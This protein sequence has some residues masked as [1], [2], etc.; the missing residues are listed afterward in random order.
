MGTRTEYAPGTFSWADLATTDVEG[1]KSFYGQLFDW[2]AEE[3]P[4]GEVGTYTMFLRNGKSVGACY[5]QRDR[6]SRPS[7][8]LTSRSTILME[9]AKPHG[10]GRKS[11]SGTGRCD[12]RGP[13]G[14]FCCFPATSIASARSW[15]CPH[16]WALRA[17]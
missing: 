9:L 3:T 14:P 6:G 4:G 16:S 13:N 1:A 15:F 10:A 5:E 12:G 8:S 7:G 17:H 11:S 2:N